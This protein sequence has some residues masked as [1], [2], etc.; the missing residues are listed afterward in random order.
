MEMTID[1]L[2]QMRG[3]PVQ[4]SSGERIGAVEDIFYDHETQRPE[5]IAIGSAQG[6]T[7]G[8]LPGEGGRFEGDEVTGTYERKRGRGRGGGRGEE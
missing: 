8:L 6:G 3:A 4:D 1:R 2:N 7:R 5:W